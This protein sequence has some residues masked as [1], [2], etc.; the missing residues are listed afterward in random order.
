MADA[1]GSPGFDW[2]LEQIR[3]LWR[4]LA[5][6]DSSEEIN[7]AVQAVVGMSHGTYWLDRKDAHDDFLENL[8]QAWVGVVGVVVG[9]M[10]GLANTSYGVPINAADA[11]AVGTGSAGKGT[12][13]AAGDAIVNLIFSVFDVAGVKSGNVTRLAGDAERNNFARFVGVN[14]QLQIADMLA[15]FVT[16]SLPWG[17]GDGLEKVGDGLQKMLGLEDAQEE[18]LQPLMEKLITE[19]LIKQ[20]NRDTKPTDLTPGDATDARIRD[21]IGEQMYQSILDNAGIMDDI[22]PTI[23]KL[24]AKNLSEADFRDLYQRGVWSRD[25]V[26][27]NFRTNGFVEE[28]ARHKTALVTGDRFW[29]LRNELLNVKESQFAA[30]VLDEGSFRSY[31]QTMNFDNAEE[32]M[33]I[34][35]A[36]GKASLR[37]GTTAKQITGTFNIAPWRIRPG[38][39]TMLSWNIRNADRIVIS[40]LGEVGP[41]GER[42]ISPQISRSFYLDAKSDT[43]SEHFEAAVQVGDTRELKRPTATFS[44]SPGRI[45]IGTPVELKWVTSGADTVTIDGLGVVGE[46]GA[47][48]V[49]P[50]LSTVYSLRATN[51]QGTTIRQDIVF[52]ELPDLEIGRD[53]RPG[54]SFSITPGVVKASQPQTELNWSITRADEGVLTFPDGH[55]E[56]VSRN[57]AMVFTATATGIFSLSAKN[58]YGD[59]HNQE[60]IIFDGAEEE[61]P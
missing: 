47:Q 27:A 2:P 3:A 45:Q 55:K 33:E 9:A 29:T 54:I 25:D 17:I 20:F 13:K 18:I 50:F 16:S 12:Q 34:E 35:I 48:A 30:G 38:Q 15:G 21:Y 42:V 5:E 37:K 11:Q 14:W 53:Q 19:G 26:F 51:S 49:Y 58:I 57:G 6:T 31:L 10:A 32:D 60:A 61:L 56:T 52:V 46:A 44:A 40:G 1:P 41:R 28:D 8:K 36:K 23:L 39:T 24:R 22:R 43:D 4:T 59:T 7:K